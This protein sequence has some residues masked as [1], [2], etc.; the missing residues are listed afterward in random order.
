MLLVG[1]MGPELPCEEVSVKHSGDGQYTVIYRPGEK[2][3]YVL[4]VK[5]GEQHIPGSPF[6]IVVQ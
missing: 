1:V 4:V 6:H 3:E 2:G 5:W